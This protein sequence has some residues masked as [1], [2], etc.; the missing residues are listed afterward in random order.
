MHDV[1][2]A[3]LQLAALVLVRK[4]AVAGTL[5][6]QP[7]WVVNAKLTDWLAAEIAVFV[8]ETV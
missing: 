7:A 6:A 4:P 2:G 5:Q 1:P 3:I 8:G